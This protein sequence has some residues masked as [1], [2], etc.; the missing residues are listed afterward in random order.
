VS[1]GDVCTNLGIL[2]GYGSGLVFYGVPGDWRYMFALGAVPAAVLFCLVWSV[3]ESPRWLVRRG[4]A[5]KA[6]RVLGQVHPTAAEARAQLEQIEA[7]LEEEAR[8]PPLSWREVLWAADPVTR[9]MVWRGLGVAFFSQATGTEAVVYYAASIVQAAGVTDVRE[10]LLAI[11]GVGLCK[12]VFLLVGCN[13]FDRTGRRPLLLIS[14]AG[15]TLSLM[16]LA[17]AAAS[18]SSAALAVFGLCAFISSFSLG[19]SPLVYVLCSEVFPSAVRARGMSLALFTTRV[20]AGVISSSFL[21]MREGLSPA[22]A[23]AFFVPVAA[24]AFAFVYLYIPETKGVALEDMPKLF[25]ARRKSRW[26]APPMT[27]ADAGVRARVA[28]TR[29][30]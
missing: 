1:I 8:K 14:A 29:I 27:M 30:A 15:L 2:L 19:F 6:L 4:R 10:T 21:S 7:D 11:M 13:L 3:P 5:A 18:S 9:T 12:V 28:A 20:V 17:G 23:W 26:C 24:C 16:L 22:G 25:A